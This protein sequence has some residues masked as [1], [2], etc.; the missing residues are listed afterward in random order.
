MTPVEAGRL[1][2]AKAKPR[3]ASVWRDAESTKPSGAACWDCNSSV[4]PTVCAKNPL[5][6]YCFGC[7][8]RIEQGAPRLRHNRNLEVVGCTIAVRVT[9]H[10][11]GDCV[12]NAAKRFSGLGKRLLEECPQLFSKDIPQQDTTKE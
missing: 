9:I 11:D 3:G 12:N 4:S 7:I 10:W 2:A 5:L 6:P 1:A 8:E